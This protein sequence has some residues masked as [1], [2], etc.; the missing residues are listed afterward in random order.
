MKFYQK[1][2]PTTTEIKILTA[3]NETTHGIY[4]AKKHGLDLVDWRSLVHSLK[5]KHNLVPSYNSLTTP[6]LPNA[7]SGLGGAI[8]IYIDLYGEIPDLYSLLDIAYEDTNA[9]IKDLLTGTSDKAKQQ[10]LF[11]F[12]EIVV[13]YAGLSAENACAHSRY[14]TKTIFAANCKEEGLIEYT[15]TSCQFSYRKSVPAY[16]HS[17]VNDTCSNCGYVKGRADEG[18]Y[19]SLEYVSTTTLGN[20]NVH[21]NLAMQSDVVSPF[22]LSSSALKAT[23]NNKNADSYTGEDGGQWVWTVLKIDLAK[24]YNA[25]SVNIGNGF[26]MYLHIYAQ[27]ASPTASI[28][29]LDENGN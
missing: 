18:D 21:S 29:Y 7:L 22:G 25:S 20:W 26:T 5:T 17:F 3:E 2:V 15:C 24:I 19:A 23:F 13:E 14:T 11:D 27:N 9:P 10:T 1:K 8:L 4:A 12:F 6:E 16:G 28:T